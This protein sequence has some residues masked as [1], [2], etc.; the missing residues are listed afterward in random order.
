MTSA[1]AIAAFVLAGLGLVG[2]N[3]WYC[4]ALFRAR[5]E[6]DAYLAFARSSGEEAV[7]SRAAMDEME[8][9]LRERAPQ[10]R[11]RPQKPTQ[12]ETEMFLP[13]VGWA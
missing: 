3:V 4:R 7:A 9:L 8:Q 6:A 12:T 2:L 10:R 13:E 11:K 1:L 5:C